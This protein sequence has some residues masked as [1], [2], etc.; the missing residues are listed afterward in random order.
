MCVCVCVLSLNYITNRLHFSPCEPIKPN[1]RP[2]RLKFLFPNMQNKHTRPHSTSITPATVLFL[3]ADSCLAIQWRQHPRTIIKWLAAALL[4][5]IIANL[6]I[7]SNSTRLTC[8]IYHVPL[9]PINK[10]KVAWM[11]IDARLPSCVWAYKLASCR[12]WPPRMQD[13]R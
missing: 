8:L 10:K 5:H 13:T 7:I 6:K 11:V 9:F 1:T 4:R 3:L 2:E 12:R